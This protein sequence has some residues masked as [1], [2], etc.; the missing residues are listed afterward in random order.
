MERK[1]R[2]WRRRRRRSSSGN[3]DY[4]D[5]KGD[6]SILFSPLVRQNVFLM[7]PIKT[8]GCYN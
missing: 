2:Q 5:G 3:D 6:Y 8:G 1:S 4:G 7:K